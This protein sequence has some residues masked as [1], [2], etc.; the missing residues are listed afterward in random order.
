[1]RPQRRDH[2]VRRG[3]ATFTHGSQEEDPY[4]DWALAAREQL[5]DEYVAL[6]TD[7]AEAYARQGQS[8]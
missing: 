3:D 7:L 2:R 1:M 5:R 6:L 8:P 4:E